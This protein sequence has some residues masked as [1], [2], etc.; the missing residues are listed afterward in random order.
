MNVVVALRKQYAF[1]E[2]YSAFNRHRESERHPIL[3][4]YRQLRVTVGGAVAPPFYAVPVGCI[5]GT[6]C[7]FSDPDY[8]STDC[9]THGAVCPTFRGD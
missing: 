5:I 8:H 3:A 2:Y 9:P 7:V 1:V 6:A 4:K